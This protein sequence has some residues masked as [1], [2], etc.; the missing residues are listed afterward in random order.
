MTEYTDAELQ[1][2]MDRTKIH[3]MR[4]ADQTFLTHVLCRTDHKFSDVVPTAGTDGLG[5]LYNK[6]FFMEHC[7]SVQERAG[8][9]VHENFHIILEHP[10]R[11]K[12]MGLD[13][14]RANAAADYYINLMI[15]DIPGLDLPEG[16]LVDE[17]YRGWSFKKIYDALPDDTQPPMDDVLS[18]G[19]TEATADKT[20]TEIK[21]AVDQ[22][23]IEAGMASM[24]AGDKPGSIPG[25]IERYIDELINPRMPWW[26]IL[27]RFMTD[28]AKTDYSMKRPNRR[29]FP[30]AYLPTLEGESICDIAT[31]VDVSG[32]VSQDD[33][34]AYLSEAAYIMGQLKPK[35]MSF[36]QW[37]TQV[38]QTD[39]CTTK[40]ELLNVKFAG[41]GGT[42]VDPT[43]QWAID[44]KP[45]VMLIFTDGYFYEPTIKPK[46][47]VIWVIVGNPDFTAPFG[48]VIHYNPDDNR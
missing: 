42:D 12:E 13:Q 23:L 47:P 44:N 14:Q 41:W 24:R 31:A 46:C 20:S 28:Y 36:L 43:L 18:P 3:L 27:R 6:Q 2:E 17:Q 16:G 32:S 9:M 25:E 26:R 29:F 21:A 4:Q 5:V 10:M 35:K 15:K 38:K 48:R 39:V 1:K 22:I 19:D 11:F 34:N 40:Q 37:D 30:D 7:K 33:F 8:L 45:K